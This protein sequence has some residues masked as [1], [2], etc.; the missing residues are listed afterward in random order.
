MKSDVFY[1][2]TAGTIKDVSLVPLNGEEIQTMSNIVLTFT[3]PHAIKGASRIT[4]K[5][6]DK[7]EFSCIL[8]YTTNLKAAPACT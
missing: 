3:P 7:I 4:V 1:T 6:P 8:A 5:M 2:P